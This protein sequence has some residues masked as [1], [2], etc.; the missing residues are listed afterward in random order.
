[1]R[2][3]TTPVAGTLEGAVFGQRLG[4]EI[5]VFQRAIPS[6]LLAEF[7][8]C[9]RHDAFGFRNEIAGGVADKGSVR[10]RSGIQ[11]IEIRQR[12]QLIDAA[13]SRMN[14]RDVAVETHP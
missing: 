9:R 2:A 7:D 3:F 5:A 4:A 14:E 6:R 11:Q 13:K 12:L 10:K 1:M 8:P